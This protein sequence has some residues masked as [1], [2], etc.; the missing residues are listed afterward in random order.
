LD[1]ALD[2]TG[3]YGELIFIPLRREVLAE[4]APREG[5]LGPL[6]HELASANLAILDPPLDLVVWF[7]AHGRADRLREGHPVFLVNDGCTHGGNIAQERPS[8]K[9]LRK[10]VRAPLPARFHNGISCLASVT[11]RAPLERKSNLIWPASP[12]VLTVGGFAQISR[13]TLD[14]ALKTVF[15]SSLKMALQTDRLQS[16]FES[17][18][19]FHCASQPL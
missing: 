10:I 14:T 16:L 17:E 13:H 19:W 3:E 15:S 8:F 5:F 2:T 12:L 18:G 11:R 6:A 1:W 9:L 7:E 4:T